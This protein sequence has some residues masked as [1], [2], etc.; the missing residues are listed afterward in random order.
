MK[1]EL[2]EVKAY[3]LEEK[4]DLCDKTYI[5]GQLTCKVDE[6]ET[7]RYEHLNFSYDKESGDLEINKFSE[8]G[9]FTGACYEMRLPEVITENYEWVSNEVEIAINDFEAAKDLER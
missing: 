9:Y 1:E 4:T 6:G 5:E 8:P 3:N 2:L 7:Y